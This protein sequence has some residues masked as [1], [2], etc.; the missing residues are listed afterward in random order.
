MRRCMRAVG[1]IYLLKIPKATG[2]G[3]ISIN[4]STLTAPDRPWIDSHLG[5]STDC[6]P[7]L[8]SAGAAT[9]SAAALKQP[10]VPS[11]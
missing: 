2:P 8:A 10:L 4:T 3:L 7:F 9:V 6:S 1:C 11:A 5:L